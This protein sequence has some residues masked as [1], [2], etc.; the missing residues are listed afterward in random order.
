ME[1]CVCSDG[2]R[3]METTTPTGAVNHYRDKQSSLPFSDDKWG[4]MRSSP[5]SIR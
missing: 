5:I 1:S 3:A 2:W 4:A